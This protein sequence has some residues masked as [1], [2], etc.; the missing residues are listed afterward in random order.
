MPLGGKLHASSGRWLMSVG[1]VPSRLSV[2]VVEGAPL[3]HIFSCQV[4]SPKAVDLG[5]WARMLDTW[6]TRWSDLLFRAL[7]K[8]DHANADSATHTGLRRA[9][10]Y[11]LQ[12]DLRL[13]WPLPQLGLD[14][15]SR[16]GRPRRGDGCYINKFSEKLPTTSGLSRSRII[17]LYGPVLQVGVHRKCKLK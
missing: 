10:A 16:D 11:I 17:V 4:Y 9:M 8:S 7:E 15:R 13:A 12:R 5:S 1:R 14:W 6:K 3:G 2:I